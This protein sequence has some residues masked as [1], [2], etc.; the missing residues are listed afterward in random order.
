MVELF[1]ESEN[2]STTEVKIEEALPVSSV[3]TKE[4][5]TEPL[6]SSIVSFSQTEREIIPSSVLETTLHPEG[7]I[8]SLA[9]T[10]E[11]MLAKIKNNEQSIQ[12]QIARIEKEADQLANEQKRLK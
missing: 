8:I 7:T 11:E 4:P 6:S 10:V 1:D 2:I 5:P 12:S 3:E 9:Q